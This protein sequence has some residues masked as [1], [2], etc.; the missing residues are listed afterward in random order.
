MLNNVFQDDFP[1][2]YPQCY[3]NTSEI[4]R[5]SHLLGQMVNANPLPNEIFSLTLLGSQRIGK[6]SAA[7]FISRGINEEMGP[8]YSR[9]IKYGSQ[10]WDWWEETDFSQTQIFFF[11]DVFPIWDDLSYTSFQDLL[12]R[13]KY[14]KIIVV[15]LLNSIE[16]HWLRRKSKSEDLVLFDHKPLF[17]HFKRPDQTEIQLILKKRMEFLESTQF[18]PQNIIRY[19]SILS[20]GLQGLELWL[21]RNVPLKIIDRN[22]VQTL[23]LEEF[24]RV[25]TRLNFEKALK[26]IID[27]NARIV[28]E[29][30]DE[31]GG[32]FWPVIDPL[33]DISPSIVRSL[34]RVKKHGIPK[35]G[36]LKEMIFL[37][38]LEG[39]IQRSELQERSGIKESSLTYQCQTLLKSGIISYFKEGREVY[40]RLSSPVREVL[41]LLY[42]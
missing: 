19:A 12:Q 13:S 7:R 34:T 35:K 38:Y 28:Q 30:K 10:F 42:F 29:D 16:D 33:K 41:E 6:S 23:S 26:L 22:K 21:I 1:L 24:Q 2:S 20:F 25:V 5:L 8:H 40:Y 31:A 27:N 11:D 17:F 3:V 4:Q 37:D 36:I 32:E 39:A 14:D 15:T 18:L 9:Y